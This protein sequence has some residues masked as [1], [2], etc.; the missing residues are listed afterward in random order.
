MVSLSKVYSTFHWLLE[1]SSEIQVFETIQAGLF[2]RL[3][4]N[5]HKEP[6]SAEEASRRT[7]TEWIETPPKAMG[8]KPWVEP[9]GWHL[10]QKVLPR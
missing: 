9:C 1:W 7:D 2:R 4:V 6:G 10:I 3:V 5:I 8:D